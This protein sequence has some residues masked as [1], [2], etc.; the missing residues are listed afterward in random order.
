MDC[1]RVGVNFQ[2]AAG[3]T[4][5]RRIE[6]VADGS[7]GGQLPSRIDP[8]RHDPVIVRDIRPRGVGVADAAF[9]CATMGLSGL[10]AFAPR[11]AR[12][13]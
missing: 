8:P 9:E 13:R 1:G 11:A 12:A 2:I 6:S 3:F 5:L 4:V 7:N 10:P